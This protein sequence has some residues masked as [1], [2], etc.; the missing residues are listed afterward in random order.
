[1]SAPH[2]TGVIACMFEEY[3]ALTASQIQKV[4]IAVAHGDTYDEAAGHGMI[5]AY[6]A[7]ELVNKYVRTAGQ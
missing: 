5:D 6:K 7:V 1:M 3:G 2:L 4:L